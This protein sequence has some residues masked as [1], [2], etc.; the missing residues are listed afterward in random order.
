MLQIMLKRDLAFTK[1]N[2]ETASAF[3]GGR[4]LSSRHEELRHKLVRERNLSLLL[5]HRRRIE[6]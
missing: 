1:K 6:R 5:T 4:S 2:E 3:R